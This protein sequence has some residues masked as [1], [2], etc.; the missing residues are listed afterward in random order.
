MIPLVSC[1]GFMCSTVSGWWPCHA[2][3]R[4]MFG[5]H[6]VSA[7]MMAALPS[8]VRHV[9]PSYLLTG[10]IVRILAPSSTP[11]TPISCCTEWCSD[12]IAMMLLVVS[13]FDRMR[14]ARITVL[15]SD[16]GAALRCGERMGNFRGT[17]AVTS[18][19][20]QHV[21]ALLFAYVATLSTAPMQVF[22]AYT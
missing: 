8:T 5:F 20:A 15:R 1:L 18:C 3:G 13:C 6:M 19:S 14:S 12:R 22:A 9:C 10:A 2:T 4:Q 11:S 17:A 7:V 21:S 16:G